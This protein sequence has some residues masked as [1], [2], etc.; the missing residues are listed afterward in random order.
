[1]KKTLFLALL[2]TCKLSIHAQLL[3][4]SVSSEISFFSDAPLDDIYAVNKEARSLI[5]PSNNEIAVVISI[6]SFKFEKAFME[7]HFNENYLE[8]DKYKT[9]VFKGR[10]NEKIDLLKD[11]FYDVSASGKL[12]IH[13][14]D[15]ERILKGTILIK[16]DKITLESG[17]KV[18]LKDHKIEIPKIVTSNIAEEVDIKV[19]ITYEPKR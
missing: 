10:I 19:L 1:M 4:N 18:A 16:G 2:L 11:G 9:A 13:G 17:F 15:Q 3:Y 6:R 12:N 14:V 7:E 8:S 5:N